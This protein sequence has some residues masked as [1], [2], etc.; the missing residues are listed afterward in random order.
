MHKTP[1]LILE[2][3]HPAALE[4]RAQISEDL[5]EMRTQLRKQ[6]SRLRELRV[7]KV[8]EPGGC[9]SPLVTNLLVINLFPDAFYGVEDPSL[10]NVDVMTDVSMPATAFTRYTVAP[11]TSSRASKYVKSHFITLS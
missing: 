3:L 5:E 2:I 1:D 10:H 9:Y 7:K 4:N 8:E 11:S 6:L